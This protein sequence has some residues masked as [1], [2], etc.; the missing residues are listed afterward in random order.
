M[1]N[2]F[3]WETIP[4]ASDNFTKKTRGYEST[5]LTKKG[6]DEHFIFR[7]H[8]GLYIHNITDIVVNDNFKKTKKAEY[9]NL[10]AMHV[11]N[12]EINLLFSDNKNVYIKTGG[13]CVHLKDLHD[14]YPSPSIPKHE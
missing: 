3:C 12:D 9:M 7:V 10:L 14:R 6:K 8:S 5:Y 4:I 1:L 11:V 13:V 2:R